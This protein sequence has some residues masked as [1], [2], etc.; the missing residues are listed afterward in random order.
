[1][2]TA[3][4]Q[5]RKTF[6]IVDSRDR[7]HTKT[8]MPGVYFDGDATQYCHIIYRNGKHHTVTIDKARRLWALIVDCNKNGS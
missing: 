2:T 3:T 6:T 7:N 5:I 4:D 8:F 1:M